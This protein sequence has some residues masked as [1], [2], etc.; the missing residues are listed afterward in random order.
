[1]ARVGSACLVAKAGTADCVMRFDFYE[2]IDGE[3]LR[4]ESELGDELISLRR[5]FE[6]LEA[7]RLNSADL[8]EIFGSRSA[9]VA[10]IHLHRL[11]RRQFDSPEVTRSKAGAFDWQ[12]DPID[13]ARYCG[14]VDG[15]SSE[16][17]N[18]GY[19][20]LTSPEPQGITV[21]LTAER[22]A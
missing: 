16:P 20:L 17:A 15:L 7:D 1:M 14:L 22:Q 2:G 21:E 8:V 4:V 3:T 9:T 19:Q 18:S 11:G 10:Q 6:D 12:A 5:L 13:L